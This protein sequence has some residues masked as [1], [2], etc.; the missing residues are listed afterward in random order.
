MLVRVDMTT[1]KRVSTQHPTQTLSTRTASTPILLLPPTSPP[2]ALA[3]QVIVVQGM[4][5]GHFDLPY[6]LPEGL[7]IGVVA[8]PDLPSGSIVC[9][10]IMLGLPAKQYVHT[11]NEYSTIK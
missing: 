11:S 5:A 6:T 8:G 4:L 1:T 2:L 9:M 3:L 10:Y 7:V